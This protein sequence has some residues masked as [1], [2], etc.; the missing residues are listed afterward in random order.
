MKSLSISWLLFHIYIKD[1]SLELLNFT[2]LAIWVLIYLDNID[3]C[4]NHGHK[5]KTVSRNN[6]V[7]VTIDFDILFIAHHDMLSVFIDLI[8]SYMNDVIMTMKMAMTIKTFQ[9]TSYLRSVTVEKQQDRQSS[10]LAPDL[11]DLDFW[12]CCIQKDATENVYMYTCNIFLLNDPIFYIIWY[13][14]MYFWRLL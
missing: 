1:L 5:E 10:G 9:T 7:N 8:R 13:I 14:Y 4:N 11:I 3:H 6:Q 12:W 2:F